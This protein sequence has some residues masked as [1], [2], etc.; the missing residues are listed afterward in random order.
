MGL[1]K[2]FLVGCV[3]LLA[4]TVP[5]QAQTDLRALSNEFTHVGEVAIPAVVYLDAEM[6]SSRMSQQEGQD[7]FQSF[8]EQFFNRFFGMR[9]QPRQ[10]QPSEVRGSGFLVSGDGYIL[11]NNH[12]VQ[13]ATKIWVTLHDGKKVE[14]QI[15]G[16][17]P[18]TDLAVIKVPGKGFPFLKLGDSSA[19]RIGEWVVA[20]GNPFGLDASLTVGVVSAKGRSQLRITDFEDFIQT[21]AAINPGNSGGPLLDLDAEVIGINTA[22]FTGSG[23]Y[24]GIGFAIPS[25]MAKPVMA[26]LIANGKVTRGFLGVQL[27]AIDSDL[28]DSF[29]LK[30]VQ[31]ALVTDVVPDSPAAKAGLKQSDIVLKYNDIPITALASFRN[32]VSFMAPGTAL[33][34]TINRDGKE[35]TLKVIIGESPDNDTATDDAIRKLGLDVET[36]TPEA[37][38]Q[39]GYTKEQGVLVRG[40]AY[41]SLAAMAGMT[42][43]DLIL[44]VGRQKITNVDEFTKTV[45]IALKDK[46][47]L[48][49]VRHG[50]QLR[51]VSLRVE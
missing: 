31:G 30:D 2:L 42:P 49:L 1:Q 7:P 27:Q 3:G 8:Q 50:Q 32:A 23:G 28:A 18:K 29:H 11:T 41:N 44:G 24:M 21:D 10:Q 5:V 19:M 37:A 33:T 6:G 39:L 9:P 17:D 47:L 14:A 51:Y 12:L 34:L 15:I 13:D 4:F 38:A 46:R 26:Q 20:V 25:N 16:T 43:G 48:L 36:L 40:V 22:I 45:Q 35:Q